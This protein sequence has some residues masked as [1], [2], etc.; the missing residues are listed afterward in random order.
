MRL[1]SDGSLVK[2]QLVT[3]EDVTV[4]TTALAGSR[5]DESIQTAGLELSLQRGLNLAR[6]LQSLLSLGLHALA[7]L[8]LLDLLLAL[9]S[10]AQR[11]AVVCFVPLSERRGVDL[12]DGGLGQGVGADQLIVARVESDDDDTDF[13]SD[14]L[15]APAEVAALEAQSAVLG[16]ASSGA[17]KVNSLVADTGVGWLTSLLEGTANS[18]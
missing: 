16:V 14:S 5:A 13:A 3:L 17:D 7:D 4:A 18:C 8:L 11:G 15:T 1:L 6:A 9:S 10:T 2:G 12:D